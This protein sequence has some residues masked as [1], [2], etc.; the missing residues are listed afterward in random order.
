MDKVAVADFLGGAIDA[1]RDI[2]L[3]IPG[4]RSFAELTDIFLRPERKMYVGAMLVALAVFFMF[5]SGD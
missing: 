1:A 5:M 4:A 3:E 2:T